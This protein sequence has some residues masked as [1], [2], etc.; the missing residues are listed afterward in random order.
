MYLVNKAAKYKYDVELHQKH[1]NIFSLL[2]S[3]YAFCDRGLN[4]KKLTNARKITP[5]P[6]NKVSN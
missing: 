3:F 1:L 6:L 4:M 5:I 2:S